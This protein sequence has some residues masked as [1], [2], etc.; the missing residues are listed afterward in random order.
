MRLRLNILIVSLLMGALGYSQT[1]DKEALF[2]QNAD[3]IVE[4]LKFHF[5][6]DQAMREYTLFKTFD[7]SITDSIESLESAEA[8]RDYIIAHNFKSDLSKKIW[9]EFINPADNKFTEYLI[10]IT[11][12]YGYPSLKRIKKYSSLE[13]DEEFNPVIFFVHSNPKYWDTIRDLIQEEFESGN[14]GKCDYGYVMWH[15]SGRK[16]LRYLDENGIDY[17]ANSKG[18]VFY[19]NTCIDE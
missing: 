17:R 13:L 1:Q 8:T 2:A 4:Y 10:D 15:I 14:M 6:Y 3:T 11:R 9:K 18:Q 5:Q 12:K 19:I 7:K 16:D